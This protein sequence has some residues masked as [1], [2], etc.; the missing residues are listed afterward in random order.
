MMKMFT[1]ALT[2]LAV[3]GTG[4][5]LTY[6]PCDDGYPFCYLL[7]SV[8]THSWVSNNCQAA[9]RTCST[10]KPATTVEPV[11]TTCKDKNVQCP[12]W[13]PV[14]CYMDR[15]VRMC[16]NSCKK[17]PTSPIVTQG[18]VTVRPIVTL[19]PKTKRPAAASTASPD[20]ASP[21][22]GCKDANPNCPIWSRYYCSMYRVATQ[23]RKSCGICKPAAKPTTTQAP[24][25]TTQVVTTKAP[26]ERIPSAN[27]KDESD[28]CATWKGYCRWTSDVGK[29]VRGMCKRT[30]NT[31]DPS[32]TQTAQSSEA[33]STTSSPT[34]PKPTTMPNQ[35]STT[36]PVETKQPE[37]TQSPQVTSGKPLPTEAKLGQRQSTTKPD[38]STAEAS[39]AVPTTTI[40]KSCKQVCPQDYRPLCG[41]DNISYMNRC[42]FQVA[43]CL[44]GDSMTV[45]SQGK[46][47]PAWA[48]KST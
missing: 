48:P 41:S 38:I 22:T 29:R 44:A 5:V 40:A 8:C 10:E 3:S 18:P 12:S 20:T 27:C 11:T 6:D 13:A 15:V 23:C 43:N 7:T 35:P 37:A 47:P 1:L 39:K 24:A 26:E 36:A 32:T 42:E 16:P 17:C 28:R 14:Y 31:C 45:K 46:C 25:V 33:P 21:D 19:R 4:S 30:C 34:E 9:C 2:L